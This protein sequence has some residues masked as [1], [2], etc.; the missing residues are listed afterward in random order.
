MTVYAVAQG[1]VDDQDAMNEYI[2]LAVPTLEAHNVKVLAFDESPK[3][4]EGAVDY[5][6]TVILEFTDADAF[7]SWYESDEYQAA[8]NHR[9][10][11]AVG[12]FILVNGM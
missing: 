6:R 12:T 2:A 1:R 10:S 11:A 8:R 7:Y 5:P 9:L 4:V 3:F